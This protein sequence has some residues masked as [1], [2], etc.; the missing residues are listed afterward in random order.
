MRALTVTPTYNEIENIEALITTF[1]DA[2]PGVDI[3][4]V[5]DASPDGTADIVNKLKEKEPRVHLLKREGRRGLGLA[6][7]DGFEWALSQ[8][9]D[10]VFSM[11]ADLSHNPKDI[12]R[13]MSLLEECD[14]VVGSRYVG[15]RVSVINW[16]ISRLILSVLAGKYVRLITGLRLSD[17]T[18]GFRGFRANVLKSIGLDTIKSNGYSFQ[19]ETL[20]RAHRCGFKISEAPIVFTERREGKSKMSLSIIL[21]AAIMPWRLR[22]KPFKPATY[23]SER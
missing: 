12:P 3:L 15:G 7:V 22:L 21:E 23:S 6:Y 4:I 13:L 1:L 2:A 11:D 5:D 18:S 9:Y 19:V 8:G 17:P 14:V 16:P 20:Y 10:A